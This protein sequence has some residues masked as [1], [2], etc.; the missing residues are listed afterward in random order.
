MTIL[1]LR[2]DGFGLCGAPAFAMI[3]KSTHLHRR[4]HSRCA[5]PFTLLTLVM[6]PVTAANFTVNNTA[7]VR[8]ANAGD[9]LCATG[10]GAC[11]LRAAIEETNALPGADAI[12]LP[13]GTFLITL[14]NGDDDAEEGDFDVTDVV[15]INGSGQAFTIIDGNAADRVFDVHEDASLRMRDVTV[16]N[17]NIKSQ[18]GGIRSEGAL[19]L[20]DVTLSDNIGK[21]GGGLSVRK[22]GSSAT[23]TRVEFANNSA[24][25]GGG[26]HIKDDTTLTITDSTFDRN[27]ADKK[28]GGLH[29]DKAVV[30]IRR[31]TIAGNDAEDGGGIFIKGGNTNVTLE[32][33]TISANTATKEGGGIQKEGNGTTRLLNVTV[34][35]NGSPRGGG[36]R[37]KDGTLSVL[38]SI[39]ANS[40]Q[41]TDCDGTI[42]S[43]GHNLD[44]DSSCQLTQAGDLP[45]IDPLLDPLQNNGG[46]TETHALQDSSPARDAGANATCLAI[47]QRGISRP[48]DGNADNIAVCDIGAFEADSL[49]PD[50]LIQKTATTLSDPVSGSS[51]AKAIPGAVVQYTIRIG[52]DGPGAADPDS[53]LITDALPPD[54]ALV[55]ND[56]DVTNPGPVAFIDGSPASGLSYSFVSL[57]SATDDVEFSNDNGVSFSYAPTPAADGSDP[58][59]THVRITPKGSAPFSGADPVAEFL[60][61]VVVR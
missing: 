39:I 11:T 14:G 23:L 24:D 49:Y 42:T 10:S 1:T 36:L 51:G 41:G 29:L 25:N 54:T 33:V 57:G 6:H 27:S 13:P 58:D 34:Y 32:N 50:Y 7:D 8:D 44:S 2:L 4:R 17:G 59:V 19:T 60:F 9:G 35:G 18:G 38:N 15:T 5:L 12:A 45:G 43:Q 20:T 40:T 52:N 37:G 26:L 53:L 56:F 21:D 30:S 16:T 31:T 22:G 47:D 55:V 61:K 3:A 48:I 46:Q 28:G